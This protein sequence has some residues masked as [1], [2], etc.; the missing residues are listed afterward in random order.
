MSVDDEMTFHDLPSDSLNLPSGPNGAVYGV[1]HRRDVNVLL[2]QC[3]EGKGELRE[4]AEK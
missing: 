1:C 3:G 4:Y 2:H